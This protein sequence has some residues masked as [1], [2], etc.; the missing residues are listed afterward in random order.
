MWTRPYGQGPAGAPEEI[1]GSEATTKSETT[2]CCHRLRMQDAHQATSNVLSGGV[3][4]PARAALATGGI[5]AL[6]LGVGSPC[7]AELWSTTRALSDTTRDGSVIL[8]KRR[9]A[10]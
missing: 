9:I 5:A 4:L 6:E 8:L 2:L 10:G 7:C 1:A 3:R